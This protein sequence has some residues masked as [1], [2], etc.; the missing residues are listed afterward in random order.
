MNG[1]VGMTDLALD[2]EDTLRNW[3]MRPTAVATG[4]EALAAVAAAVP[5]EPFQLILLDASMP[6]M[7]GFMFA[8]RLR[9]MTDS[10]WPTIMML[11]SAGQRGDAARC[12]GL[13]IEAYLLKPLKCSELLQATQAG[14]LERSAR[15]PGQERRGEALGEGG[16]G[17]ITPHPAAPSRSPPRSAGFP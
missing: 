10:P 1:I 17:L 16:A 14:G 15:D 6:G 13:G 4:A 9:A 5:A 2:T 7:D 12:R 3:A 11:S 8:E